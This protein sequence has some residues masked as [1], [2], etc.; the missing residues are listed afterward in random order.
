MAALCSHSAAQIDH[1]RGDV[2]LEINGESVKYSRTWKC[3]YRTTFSMADGRFSQQAEQHPSP[4]NSLVILRFGKRGIVA[5]DEWEGCSTEPAR[6]DGGMWVDL[7]D[8]Y[9]QPSYGETL[10]LRPGSAPTRLN[11]V[12]STFIV[13]LIRARVVRIDGAQHLAAAGHDNQ[14]GSDVLAQLQRKA[15]YGLEI[16]AIAWN[17]RDPIG[18]SQ[19]VPHT[20]RGWL[21]G[22]LVAPTPARVLET[23][24]RN[25]FK[26]S[27]YLPVQWDAQSQARTT[28]ASIQ[29]QY[30]G[31][32]LQL[33]AKGNAGVEEPHS[34]LKRAR[35][36]ARVEPNRWFLQCIG[37]FAKPPCPTAEVRVTR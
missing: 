21:S 20:S 32:V 8:D 27:V 18:L 1:Y 10:Y 37:M 19:P 33:D 3:R 26:E 4:P 17:E 23:S 15:A 9:A 12:D 5:F 13:R 31:A 11:P 6:A 36:Y 22:P 28:F 34:G 30:A 2:E 24:R 25:E 29:V 35:F 14:L 7:L 16:R